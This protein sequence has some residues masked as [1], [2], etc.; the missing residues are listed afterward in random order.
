MIL[1]YY[2]I[3]LLR[4]LHRNIDGHLAGS[5]KTHLESIDDTHNIATLYVYTFQD[6]AY[7]SSH[8]HYVYTHEPLR[9]KEWLQLVY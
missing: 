1:S 6:D 7:M 5:K 2:R 8:M 9:Y 4:S 3:G